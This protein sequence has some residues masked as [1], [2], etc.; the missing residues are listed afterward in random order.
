VRKAK[1]IT[2]SITELIQKVQTGKITLVGKQQAIEEDSLQAIARLSTGNPGFDCK[3]C[4]AWFKPKPQQW[5][6]HQLCDSCF[7]VFDRQKMM[8]RYARIVEKKTVSY[9]EDVDDWIKQNK[10]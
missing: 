2:I 8:G 3:N 5:I 10:T 4:G 1:P 7:A 6:F 9:F